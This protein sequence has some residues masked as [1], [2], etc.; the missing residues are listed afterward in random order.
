MCT[1]ARKVPVLALMPLYM[2]F[3][4]THPECPAA[5]TRDWQEGGLVLTSVS[6]EGEPAQI[7]GTLKGP[8]HV[9]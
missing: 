6:G 2:S 5:Q 4:L 8:D 7:T 1:Q 9:V 3:T